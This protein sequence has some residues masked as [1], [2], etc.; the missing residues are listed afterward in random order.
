V[1]AGVN[2]ANEEKATDLMFSE[3]KRFTDELVSEEEMSDS[4]S[5]FIGSLPLS[6]E[7]NG[8]VA[9]ALL[10]IER[11]QL[12]LDYYES[13]PGEVNAVT[14]EQVRD[15]AVKHLQTDRFAVAVA[16]PPRTAAA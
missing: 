13:F 10:N 15:T 12:G 2:P 7:S 5:N 14:R 3:V 8:G 16:G 9:D 11:Y 6:L 1:A 4:K